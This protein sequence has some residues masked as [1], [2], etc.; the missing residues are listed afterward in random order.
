[1]MQGSIV[2][3]VTPFT[4]DNQID[5]T[6]LANLVRWH[7]EEGTDGIVCLGTTGEASTLSAI[8][9]EN[10][11][12]TIVSIAKGRVPVIV[13]TGSNDTQSAVWQTTL[14][15]DLG[16]DG[17]LVV[18]PYYNRP[19]F[20]GCMLH[21]E[22]LAKVGLPILLYYHPTRTG[23]RLAPEELAKISEIPEIFAIKDASGDINYALELRSHTKKSIFSGDDA[24]SLPLMSIGAVGNI[25][26]IAN[27]IPREWKEMIQLCLDKKFSQALMLLDKYYP[28]AQ[29]L[30]RETNP[31]CVKYALS[32]LGKVEP[33]MRSPLVVPSES[34]RME[35]EKAME[36]LNLFK[37]SFVKSAS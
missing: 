20:R 31:Q 28:L 36:G 4:S 27:V 10:I 29:S 32:L 25:S 33:F 12:A 37:T 24:L 5:Y 13:G 15:K 34:T 17:A 7:L 26:I 30:V 8:E 23:V 16:A 14:A 19:G 1:M 11:I 21:Y 2:A 35:I 18:M 22:T 9:K 3:I 6:A